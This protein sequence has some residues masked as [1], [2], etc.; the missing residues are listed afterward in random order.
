V[1]MFEGKPGWNAMISRSDTGAQIV[2]QA[3]KEGF[4][5]TADFPSAN[6]KH[7]SKAASDKKDRSLRTLIRRGLIN[8]KDGEHA[9]IRIPHKIVK[10]I[11]S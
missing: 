2:D 3:R 5:E 9:A 6:L 8:N 1:G 11:L 10:K 4:I 7:L